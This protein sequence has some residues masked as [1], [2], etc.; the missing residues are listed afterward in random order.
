MY[1][2]HHINSCSFDFEPLATSSPEIALQSKHSGNLKPPNV[3]IYTGP[4]DTDKK[5]YSSLKRALTQVLK[6]H[7]YAIYRLD[8]KIITTHPWIENTALLVLEHDN[9]I[10]Q[11]VQEIFIKYVRGGGKLLSLNSSFILQVIKK[12]WSEKGIAFPASV[13]IVY[14]KFH[15]KRSQH[16][17]AICQPFYFEGDL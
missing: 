15:E 3:L 2:P 5:K 1:F 6:L 13:E 14:P 4:D 9:T 8:D 16:L 7:S 17:T 11:P 12:Q 10:S